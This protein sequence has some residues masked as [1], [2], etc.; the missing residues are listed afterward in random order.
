MGTHLSY[1]D[2]LILA[3]MVRIGTL[4]TR[5][6]ALD[7]GA[8][9]VYCEEIIDHK[10]IKC[11][12]VENDILNTVD[13]VEIDGTVVFR[14]CAKEKDH[15][16]FQMGTADPQRAL[17]V[18]KM[19]ENDVAGIDVN[20]GCPKDYSTKG[21]MGAALLQHPEKIKQVCCVLMNRHSIFCT[22]T[23]CKVNSNQ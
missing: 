9:I 12:R 23:F 19:V 10:L 17:K 13:F 20:M 4:P 16:V 22:H 7:Y 5:L 1:A 6:L 11:R 15:V 8:D 14:T 3:P 2:K 18:A 21:G